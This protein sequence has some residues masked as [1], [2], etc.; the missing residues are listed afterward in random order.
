[1][2]EGGRS[3]LLPA[4]RLRE[5][6]FAIA[7]Y[8]GTGFMA[9]AAALQSAYAHL[10]DTGSTAHLPVP[11]KPLTEMHALLGFPA[12]WEFE[13]RWLSTEDPDA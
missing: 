10:R 8:P 6:G 2:V 9:A 7:I 11:L 13:Q 3:P 12:V 1:M 4:A 5:L